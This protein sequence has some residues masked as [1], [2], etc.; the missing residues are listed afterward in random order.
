TP[1]T[2]SFH[3][4]HPMLDITLDGPTLCAFIYPSAVHD[5]I[6]N[7]R[8]SSHRSPLLSQV[9]PHHPLHPLPSSQ[10]VLEIHLRSHPQ[11][12]LSSLHLRLHVAS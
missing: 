12:L 6:L 1:H 5:T 8:S 9:R 10:N 2:L 7:N 3:T 11:L 4:Y